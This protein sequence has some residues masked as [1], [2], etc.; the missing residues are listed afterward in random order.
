MVYL[1]MIQATSDPY[2]IIDHLEAIKQYLP[3]EGNPIFVYPTGLTDF[4]IMQ[5]NVDSMINIVEKISNIPID[6]SMYHTGMLDVHER[7]IFL[8]ENIMDAKSWM[9][10]SIPSILFNSIWLVGTLGFVESMMRRLDSNS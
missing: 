7:A 2:T 3:H 4:A 10:F 5:Q 9:L 6:S 8:R 1:D